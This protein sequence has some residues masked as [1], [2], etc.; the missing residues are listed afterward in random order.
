MTFEVDFGHA[1]RL[2]SAAL[3]THAPVFPQAQLE[4]WGRGTRGEWQMLAKNPA[5]SPRVP[6]DLRLDAARA[7]RRAGFRYLLTPTGAGGNA[8]IGNSIVGHEA[9]WGMER[10]ADAGRFYLLRVK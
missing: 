10:A 4:I 1:Q 6:Q 9:D 3:V 7:L 5:A 8:P 2:T